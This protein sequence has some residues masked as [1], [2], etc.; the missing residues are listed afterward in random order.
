MSEN[1]SKQ[2]ILQ[3]HTNVPTYAAFLAGGIIIGVLLAWGWSTLRASLAKSSVAAISTAKS[4]A[5]SVSKTSTTENTVL[6]AAFAGSTLTIEDQKAGF[7]VAIEKVSVSVPTWVVVYAN[8]SGKPGR[9]LGAQL[10]FPSDESGR[11]TLLRAT[12]AGQMYLVL[13]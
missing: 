8:D 13:K 6:V 3:L 12:E 9:I 7:S 5:G 2:P 11:V 1:E 4:A 10:F